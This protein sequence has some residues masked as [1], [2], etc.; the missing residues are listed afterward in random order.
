MEDRKQRLRVNWLVLVLILSLYIFGAILYPQL[1]DMVPSHWNINGE[2]D[3]YTSKT[4]HV[5]GFPTLILGMYLLM[6]FAPFLDPKP[7]S[8]KK[9]A[10][11]FG[12]FRLILVVVLSVLY[13]ATN[14]VALGFA[15]S[16]GKITRAVIGAMLVYIGNYFGKV[17]H[18]YTFGIKTPWTIASEE[19]WNK[20]HRVSGPLWAVT[21]IIWML[22][23]FL[24]ER[25]AFI[26]DMA[27][28]FIVSGYGTV[29][30]YIL[31]RR[32]NNPR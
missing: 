25:T 21:G 14:L 2:V 12:G 23:I 6:T 28:L 15:I 10:G 24:P 29:Y 19:V 17:R 1:P 20:T 32:L 3:G 11:V 18:N 27:L 30:S 9:F 4:A 5:I 22:S 7:E 31:F 8:Y 16:V 26:V 13:L